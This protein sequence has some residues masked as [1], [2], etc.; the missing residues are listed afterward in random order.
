MSS[1]PLRCGCL[2]DVVVN[3]WYLQ[4]SSTDCSG[5]RPFHDK[6]RDCSTCSYKKT[7][8]QLNSPGDRFQKAGRK[9]VR[10]GLQHRLQAT[11]D[12]RKL[13]GRLGSL[14]VAGGDLENAVEHLRLAAEVRGW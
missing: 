12:D 8:L 13:L 1:R 14:E 11:P 7:R 10:Q 5:S 2:C 3:H 4:R 9:I 6:H